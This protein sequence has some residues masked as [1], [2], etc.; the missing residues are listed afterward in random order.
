MVS[1]TLQQDFNNITVLH[2]EV[3]CGLIVDNALAIEQES[4]YDK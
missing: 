3:L 2:V 1:L 4:A